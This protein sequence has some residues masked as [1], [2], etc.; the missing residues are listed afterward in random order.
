[1][2]PTKRKRLGELLKE[3]GKISKLEL[4]GAIEE[5]QGKLIQ[6]GEV[7]F[8]RGQV[9]K[10]DLVQALEEVI[11]V[12][13]VDCLEEKP[14]PQ[15]I[16]LISRELADRCCALPLRKVGGKLMVV[17]AQP[18]DL[19]LLDQLRFSAGIEI[20]PRMGFRIEIVAAIARAYSVSDSD[21][22]EAALLEAQTT[23][24]VNDEISKMEFV[25]TSSRQSNR[26]AF[27]EIQAELLS[28]RTPAVRLVSEI[29]TSALEKDASDIHIEPQSNDLAV[30][31]RVD[32]VLRDLRRI[33]R[34]LQNSLVSRIKILSDMDIADR[35]SPQD[36]RFQVKSQGR[37]LE[38]RVSTLPTQF[39][40]KVVMRLL[41]SKAAIKT[42]A[43]LGLEQ[44]LEQKLLRLLSLPQG[45]LLV[46]GPTGSGK[47]TTLYAALTSLKNSS[48]NIVTV[49][50]PVEY[51]LAGINQVHVNTRAGLTFASCLRSILRQDPNIIMVGEIRDHET[52]EICMKAAQTG[53][54][55][56]ST[57]HT[58]DSI[59]AILRLIDLGIA[60]SLLAAS[61]TGILAQRLIRKLCACHSHDPASQEYIEQFLAAGGAKA[62][63]W[64]NTPVGCPECDQTGFKGRLGIYE[65]L[66]FGEGVRTLVRDSASGSQIRD[67]LR[68]EGMRLMQEDALDKVA[69]GITTLDEVLRVVPFEAVAGI[70]CY[71][72]SHK[73]ATAVSF[74][75]F[76][77]ARQPPK[78]T[79]STSNQVSE[80]ASH[81]HVGVGT[82]SES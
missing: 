76:C 11:H 65:L 67:F 52:A 41:E 1:M 16:Q 80:S 50:D 14:D 17:L 68:S 27:Q 2:P 37:E 61:V 6:L 34:A 26:E 40:E 59:S 55:V 58:N 82:G 29:I 33:P 69:L 38:M 51:V 73:L 39:G 77:G 15:V 57:L 25:S 70:D 44:G 79:V 19:T 8:E 22:A 10:A 66:V 74:C 9:G 60:P 48:V 47:S 13:Y 36:G 32:G 53:H 7:L 78:K 35:R 18:Q 75:P 62:P 30:R 3:R 63:V 54:L 5:Q 71:K 81:D 21:V 20:L 43:D 42:F 4:E 46:T 31:L 24:L 64:R 56:L 49:E 45:T 23:E 12:P 28:F 72:C